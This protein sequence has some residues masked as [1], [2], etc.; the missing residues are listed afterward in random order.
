[1][2]HSSSSLV[3]SVKRKQPELRK[4]IKANTQEWDAIAKAL[5]FYYPFAGRLREG[6]GR[7]LMVD[8][9]GEGCCSLKLKLMYWS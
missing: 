5:V 3:F 6:P 1:M 2:S 8:C 4:T 7:K 9:T